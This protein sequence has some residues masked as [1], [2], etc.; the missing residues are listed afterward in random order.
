MPQSDEDARFALSVIPL[1][2]ART[3]VGSA[4]LDTHPGT[5]S[6]RLDLV[7]ACLDPATGSRHTFIGIRWR[8][9]LWRAARTAASLSS[10]FVCGS[11]IVSLSK[12][13][14]GPMDTRRP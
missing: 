7:H 2:L 3:M 12:I 11:K 14:A 13:R 1:A 4:V 8:L 10:I 5:P 9:G 6:M